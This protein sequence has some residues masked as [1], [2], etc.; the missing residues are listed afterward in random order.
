MSIAA[1]VDE[2]DQCGSSRKA[3]WPFTDHQFT[4]EDKDGNLRADSGRFDGYDA[5]DGTRILVR[6]DGFIAWK[7]TCHG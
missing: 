5:T 4:K 3:D 1:R 2:S 7:D 6:P